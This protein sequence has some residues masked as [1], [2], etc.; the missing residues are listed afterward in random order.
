VLQNAR[1]GVHPRFAAVP[2]QAQTATVNIGDAEGYRSGCS[3]KFRMLDRRRE[4]F[5]DGRKGIQ[6]VIPFSVEELVKDTGK[7][8]CEKEV[9]KRKDE[10][11]MFSTGG[12]DTFPVGVLEEA[13]HLCGERTRKEWA[14]VMSIQ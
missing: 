3:N 5:G 12:G 11:E 6:E 1:T 10:K 4:G 8:G 7:E 2:T 14:G 13:C 9:A